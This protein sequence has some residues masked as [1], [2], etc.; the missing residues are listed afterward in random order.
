MNKVGEIYNKIKTDG[1]WNSLVTNSFWAFFGDS[2]A[3]L[4]NLAITIFLI[5][6]I[7][8]DNYGILVLAQSYM[9]IVDIILNVQ[10]WKGVIQYSQKAIANKNLNALYEYIN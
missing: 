4:I 5:K 2:T 9:S 10:C 3:S 7:G 1:F 8:N 6:L